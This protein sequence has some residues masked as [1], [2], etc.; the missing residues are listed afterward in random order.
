MPTGDRTTFSTSW[1]LCNLD[2]RY[3]TDLL[4]IRR[5]TLSNSIN[6]C[7]HYLLEFVHPCR[8]L[9]L[10]TLLNPEKRRLQINEN[11]HKAFDVRSAIV[12]SISRVLTAWRYDVTSTISQN[13]ITYALR[14]IFF[15]ATV[16]SKTKQFINNRPTPIF[17]CISLELK[18]QVIF[19]KLICPLSVFVV[20]AN[21]FFAIYSYSSTTPK[22]TDQYL[23]N[24]AQIN[25]FLV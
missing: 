1:S 9:G 6:Q 22:P 21:L 20:V 5:K 25:E 7:N 10:A 24:L 18:A 13:S 15:S 19:S 17:N 16:S 8:R 3:M 11:R 23:R 14:S 12:I 4:P 2:G